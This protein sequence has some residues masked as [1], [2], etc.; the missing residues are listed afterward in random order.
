G[1]GAVALLTATVGRAAGRLAGFLAGLI[2][3]ITPVAALM[4]RFNNPDALLVLLLVAGAY[5]LTGALET[6]STRW[7]V[8]AGALVGFAFLAKLLQAFLVIPA[9][10]LVYLWAAPASLPRRIAQVG[11]AAL[12][13]LLSAGWY[14]ALV[15]LWPADARPYIGGSQTNSI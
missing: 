12:A 2:L 5:G 9:F 15:M 1:V 10:T 8:F 6:A 7:I 13:V 4:F 11:A 14:V 3:A